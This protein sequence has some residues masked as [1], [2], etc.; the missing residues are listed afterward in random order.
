MK[1]DYCTHYD[2]VDPW[3]NS[4]IDDMDSD[5]YVHLPQGPGLGEDINFDY[6]EDNLVI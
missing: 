5:G 6:I 1:G 3:L 2:A 4:K